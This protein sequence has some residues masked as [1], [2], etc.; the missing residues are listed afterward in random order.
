MPS[1]KKFSSILIALALA[2]SACESH[3]Y[4]EYQGAKME[5]IPWPSDKV[6]TFDFKISEAG[7]HHVILGM[8]HHAY[9]G[10]NAIKTSVS[11]SKPDGTTLDK[12]VI[13]M[14]KD[15]VSGEHTGDVSGDVGDIEQVIFPDLDMETGD[16]QVKVS[17]EMSSNDKALNGV[18][19]ISVIVDKVEKE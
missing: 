2:F 9:I 18:F 7:K 4:S 16:Y 8:R 19:G 12:K 6:F 11:L 15:P 10:H 14:I 3:V 5:V 1:S 13:L 17:Q